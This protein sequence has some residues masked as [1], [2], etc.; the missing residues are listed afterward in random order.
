MTDENKTHWLKNP[1]KNYLGHFDLPGGEDAVLTIKSAAWEDVKDPIRNTVEQK[2]IVRFSENFD[3]VK[4]FICNET[5]AAMVLKTTTKKYMEDCEGCKLQLGV[6]KI[7][8]K[9]D[10]VDCIRIRDITSSSF[11]EKCVSQDQADE[12]KKLLSSAGKTEA[13]VC[14]AMKISDLNKLKISKFSG[15]MSKLKALSND[16]N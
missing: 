16:N 2:R 6:S 15:V 14:S 1:N 3:W 4:P 7:K 11:D 10:M 13:E 8:V 12:I 5:N 9:R